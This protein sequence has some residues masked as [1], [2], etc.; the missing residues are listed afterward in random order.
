MRYFCD[1]LY[2]SVSIAL[3][4]PLTNAF[5]SG[6]ENPYFLSWFDMYLFTAFDAASNTASAM[7]GGKESLMK[8]FI[9]YTAP[10]AFPKKYSILV[11]IC[12]SSA[13][14]WVTSSIPSFLNRIFTQPLSP[15]DSLCSLFASSI[16]SDA[17]YR[18]E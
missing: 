7:S 18:S 14:C 13:R 17:L 2:I 16:S 8:S 3:P 4:S 15:V 9:P 11:V 5:G 10:F 12:S 6:T 1:A